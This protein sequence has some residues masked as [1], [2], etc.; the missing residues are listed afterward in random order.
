[1]KKAERDDIAMINAT[2][3]R[4]RD[5]K[6]RLRDEDWAYAVYQGPHVETRMRCPDRHHS[7]SLTPMEAL[8]EGCPICAM[9]DAP[10]TTVTV[11]R[12]KKDVDKQDRQELKSL[13]KSRRAAAR[14][15]GYGLD[16]YWMRK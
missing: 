1:M 15:S 9:M 8:T 13:N 14:G 10:P 11:S 2:R 7:V 5:I 4:D 12:L 3:D 16:Q 6:D